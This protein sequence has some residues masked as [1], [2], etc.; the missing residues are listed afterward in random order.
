MEITNCITREFS[1]GKARTSLNM[2]KVRIKCSRPRDDL[3]IKILRVFNNLNIKCTSIT[4]PRHAPDEY[5][6]SCNSGSDADRIFDQ[7][8]S[9]N[10]EELG[11]KAIIPLKLKAERSVLLKR[12]DRIIYD[13][14]TEDI[15]NEIMTKNE[16]LE[17]IEVFKF[18]NSPIIKVTFSN[19]TMAERTLRN[20]LKI[21]MMFIPPV[22]IFKDEF[23]EIKTCFRCFSLNTHNTHDCPKDSSYI[24]CSKCSGLGHDFRS[25][26]ET[27]KKCIN[28]QLSHPTLSFSCPKR[29]EIVKQLRTMEEPNSV[30]YASIARPSYNPQNVAQSC[31]PKIDYAKMHSDVVKSIMCLVIAA[32]KENENAGSFSEVLTKLQETNNVPNFCLGEVQMPVSFSNP[33]TSFPTFNRQEQNILSNAPSVHTSTS[34]P[35]SNVDIPISLASH[36]TNVLEQNLSSDADSDHTE[37]SLSTP[38]VALPP[39]LAD[40]TMGSPQRLNVTVD[41]PTLIGPKISIVKKKNCP[42]IS[43]RNIG[44]LLKQ[45]YLMFKHD[46]NLSNVQCLEYF[47]GNLM[48]CKSAISKAVTKEFPSKVNK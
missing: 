35:S 8:C 39:S 17:V 21:F 1:F 47:K 13:N 40:R 10:L 2:N 41:N 27:S 32:E 18:P 24:I 29:K 25:C 20:G 5:V 11:C 4:I 28:C 46:N 12:V 14:E 42:P 36:R 9:G 38:N 3:K 19:C 15:K 6:I 37:T 7:N 43:S 30:S 34:L 45:G 31:A 22:C 48:E 26:V 44:D 23:I 33:S 16:N